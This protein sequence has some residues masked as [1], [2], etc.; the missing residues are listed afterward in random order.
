MYSATE[1]EPTGRSKAVVSRTAGGSDDPPLQRGAHLDDLRLELVTPLA[2]PLQ[3]FHSGGLFLCQACTFL[4]K[5]CLDKFDPLF[6]LGLA[7]I[8]HL[9][10]ALHPGHLEDER[11]LIRLSLLLD[12]TQLDGQ[13]GIAFLQSHMGGL[14]GRMR[15]PQR[16]FVLLQG[17]ELVVQAGDL[18]VRRASCGGVFDS[19]AIE[20]FGKERFVGFERGDVR[21]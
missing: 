13:L 19:N 10:Q 4:Q 6:S 20:F 21:L 1:R 12:L 5:R 15:V 16:G 11:T 8:H 3:L 17:R 9:D 2:F 14:Q 18:H 7:S